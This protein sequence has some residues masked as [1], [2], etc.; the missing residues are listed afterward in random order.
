MDNRDTWWQRMT[1]SIVHCGYRVV[2]DYEVEV[3]WHRRGDC[4]QRYTG[5][6]KMSYVP[7]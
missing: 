5:R 2:V 1:T 7:A 3:I 6:S 4:I